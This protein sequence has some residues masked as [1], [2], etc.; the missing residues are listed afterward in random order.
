MKTAISGHVAT[1]CD[2]SQSTDQMQGARSL[3]LRPDSILS[4]KALIRGDVVHSGGSPRVSF[5][6]LNNRFHQFRGRR[7]LT[8]S[9]AASRMLI[10]MLDSP[11]ILQVV[12]E[13]L[14]AVGMIVIRRGGKIVLSTPLIEYGTHAVHRIMRFFKSSF[15]RNSR[16]WNAEPSLPKSYSS[17]SMNPAQDSHSSRSRTRSNMRSLTPLR[18][19]RTVS[20]ITVKAASSLLVQEVSDEPGSVRTIGSRIFRDSVTMENE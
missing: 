11:S 15:H 16:T 7:R 4:W 13:S 9:S 2:L 5:S 1:S 18:H 8:E 20:N 12:T 19:P 6:L 10:H 14:Q 17:S 3:V